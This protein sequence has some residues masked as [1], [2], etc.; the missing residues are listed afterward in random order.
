[1]GAQLSKLTNA[2]G[3]QC[4]TQSSDKHVKESAKTVEEFLRSKNKALPTQ[5]RTPMRSDYK[6]ERDTSP[7]VAA[8]GHSFYQELIGILCWAVELGVGDMFNH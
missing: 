3:T 7:E 2:N 5:L 1:L 6:P 8:E 4:C